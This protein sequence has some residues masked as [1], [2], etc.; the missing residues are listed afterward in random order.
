[1]GNKKMNILVTGGAGFIGSHT[2]RLL[3][4]KKYKIIIL[5]N[6]SKGHKKS[7]LKD[8]KFH[9]T[10]LADK[11]NIKK[12]FQENKIDAVMHFAGYI[13][14]EESMKRPKDFYRNNV[15]TT[16]NLLDVMLEFNV[17]NLIF[18]SSAAIF[19]I[20]KNIPVDEDAEKNPFNVYGTTKLIVEKIL[21]D[22]DFTYGL[23]SICLRYFNAAGAGYGIGEDHNPETHLIP[24]VLKVALGKNKKIQ[25]FGTDY[26]TKD[27]TCIRDYIHVLDLADA[28]I[29]A[30]QRLLKTKKSEQYNLG[31]EQGYS[32]R[33]IIEIA[34]EITNKKILVAEAKRRVGDIPILI[35][36][37]SKIKKELGWNPKFA[38]RDI[39]KSAW[40]W[41]KN[42]PGGF[43]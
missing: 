31:S 37:S 18:S 19:G 20:P 13:E 35:A 26:P 11:N 17:K 42:N 5:D 39:I 27:G 2:V 16:I 38:L 8:V 15:V 36:D 9:K 24:L 10:D 28:H 25:I 3:L 1:M 30:L 14:A 6:L 7:I 33:E 41:H 21:N 40:E 29:L 43:K 23:K 22:Y 32:V 34:R 4:N 12:I